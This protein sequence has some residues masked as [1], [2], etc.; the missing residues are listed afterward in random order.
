MLARKI[1]DARQL[2]VVRLHGG[3]QLLPQGL[4]KGGVM[5]QRRA[6]AGIGLYGGQQGHGGVGRLLG[7]QKQ[8]QRARQIV[9]VALVVG[10]LHA[11]SHA[12]IKIDDALPAVLVV[13]VRLNGDAAQRRIAVNIVGLAQH[14]VPRGEAAVEQA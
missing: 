5:R 3:G 1:E 14:P 2:L 12:V 10:L 6:F 13:L 7:A 4:V 11:G 8:L 9:A